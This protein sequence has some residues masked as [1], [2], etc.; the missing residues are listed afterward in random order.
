MRKDL[1]AAIIGSAYLMSGSVL[2]GFAYVGQG[3]GND[4]VGILGLIFG[5]VG[6]IIT[7]YYLFFAGGADDEVS[8]DSD[9][10]IETDK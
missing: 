9:N 7:V 6:I 1:I 2:I 4:F 10:N 3:K 5:V 8:E